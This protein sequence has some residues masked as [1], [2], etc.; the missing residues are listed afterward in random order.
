MLRW[1]MA[2]GCTTYD[3]GGTGTSYPPQETDKGY[4]VYQFKQSFGAQIVRWY[5]YA[6]CV[7][8]PARYTAFRLLERNLPLGE[9][10][11]IEWPKQM[12]YR[13]RPKAARTDGSVDEGSRK[14]TTKEP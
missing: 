11:F 7:F 3:F 5:G 8:A 12:L 9:R 2:Q 10:V 14:T 1:A 4:G 6:D 13:W